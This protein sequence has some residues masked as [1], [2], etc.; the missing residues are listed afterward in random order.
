MMK[1]LEYVSL[2]ALKRE[3]EKISYKIYSLNNG[4]MDFSDFLKDFNLKCLNKKS[5]YIDR[6]NKTIYE[7]DKRKCKIKYIFLIQENI[8][9]VNNKTYYIYK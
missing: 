2:Q 8:I 3:N 6:K 1:Q 7:M 9:D 5:F 4:K